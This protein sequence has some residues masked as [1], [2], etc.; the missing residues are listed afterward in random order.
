MKTFSILGCGYL[1]LPLVKSISNEYKIKVL[2]RSKT[3]A[4]NFNKLGFTSYILDSCNKNSLEEFLNCDVLFIALPP[5]D[6]NYLE[7]LKRIYKN[8]QAKVQIIFISSTSIYPQKDFEFKEDFFIQDDKKSLVNQAEKIVKN[9]TNII[10]R[11]AGL[12]GENRVPGKYFSNKVVK[13]Y[14]AKVNY[15]HKDDVIKAVKFVMKKKI[16]GIYNLCSASHPSKKEIYLKN[17]KEFDF[18][19]PIF[20]FKIQ[21]NELLNRIINSKKLCE[22]G[23]IYTY[24]NPLDFKY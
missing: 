16:E 17:A 5:K 7:I 2:T 6:E 4:L 20:D 13:N 22:E 8:V 21:E 23:F 12:M 24:I 18:K 11:C 19:K 15:V 10:F 3:K 1:G 14:N 9:R